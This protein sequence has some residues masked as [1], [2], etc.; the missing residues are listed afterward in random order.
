M[1]NSHLLCLWRFASAKAV[2]AYDQQVLCHTPPNEGEALWLKLCWNGLGGNQTSEWKWDVISTMSILWFHRNAS[3]LQKLTLPTANR[4]LPSC[5]SR[6]TK[7]PGVPRAHYASKTAAGPCAV[8]NRRFMMAPSPV[9][10][11]Y[12]EVSLVERLVD[13]CCT[14][15]GRWFAKAL[16][17]Q[18]VQP[19]WKVHLN[20]IPSAFRLPPN[21]GPKWCLKIFILTH[22]SYVRLY[23]RLFIRHY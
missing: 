21:C 13:G 19:G 8:Q 20:D 15:A 9:S 5:C 2:A 23:D 11:P 22:A 16:L 12:L 6:I 17:W 10:L 4:G 7:A 18:Y 1:L 3:R 14:S